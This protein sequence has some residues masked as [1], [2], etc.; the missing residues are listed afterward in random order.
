MA[1]TRVYTTRQVADILG[2][3]TVTVRAYNHRH[4]MP[5]PVDYTV[6]GWPLFDADVI[7]AWHAER[8]APTRKA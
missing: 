4:Q 2:V 5:R 8:Q 6:D 3:K 7:D 1:Q